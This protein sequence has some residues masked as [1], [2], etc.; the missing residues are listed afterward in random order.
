MV[1]FNG[2]HSSVSTSMVVVAV[3]AVVVVVVGFSVKSVVVFMVVI[4]DEVVNIQPGKL[5]NVVAA[6]DTVGIVVVVTVVVDGC[7]CCCRC[8][9]HSGTSIDVEKDVVD[10]ADVIV[11]GFLFVSVTQSGSFSLDVV[12]AVVVVDIVVM[13]ARDCLGGGGLTVLNMI[14]FILSSSANFGVNPCHH[15][16]NE[17]VVVLSVVDVV[18][19]PSLLLLVVG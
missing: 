18:S 3:V 6:E 2:N 19:A 9:S 11:V 5:T 15:G 13:S 1:D 17:V 8:C 10:V 14:A 16:L 4:P 7:C 12:A